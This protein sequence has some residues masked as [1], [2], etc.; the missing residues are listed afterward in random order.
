MTQNNLLYFFLQKRKYL[1]KKKFKILKGGTFKVILKTL[2]IV[3]TVY[4]IL[5]LIHNCDIFVYIFTGRVLSVREPS[6]SQPS[7][8]TQ[9][10]S[11]PTYT[12]PRTKMFVL[13]LA[14]S[15]EHRERNNIKREI[16]QETTTLID[17]V[18][19]ALVQ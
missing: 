17:G 4:C 18:S 6:A 7:C 1:R 2:A 12:V 19:K 15:S 8:V 14:S 16:S 5:H 10:V 9:T 11:S 13:S 3:C